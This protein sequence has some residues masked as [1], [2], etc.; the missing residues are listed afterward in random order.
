MVYD[1]VVGLLLMEKEGPESLRLTAMQKKRLR[2][3]SPRLLERMRASDRSSS[4][5]DAETRS[6]L[7]D[8]QLTY[9]S[10]RFNDLKVPRDL[11]PQCTAF[12]ALIQP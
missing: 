4:S 7:S 12:E 8:D 1:V 9:I 10:D 6:C 2:E 5:L 11:G 3:I